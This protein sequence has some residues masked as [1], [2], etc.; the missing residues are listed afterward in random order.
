MRQQTSLDKLDL[1][2]EGK[3]AN[4][5]QVYNLAVFAL[6]AFLVWYLFVPGAESYYEGEQASNDKIIADLNRENNYLMSVSCPNTLEGDRQCKVNNKKRELNIAKSNL[7]DIKDYNNHFTDKLY[8]LSTLTYNA[9]NWAKFLDSLTTIANDNNVKIKAITSSPKVIL[10]KDVAPVLDI[11]VQF[12]GQFNK[13]LSFLNSI[14]ES[15]LVVDINKMDLNST[16]T[17]IF[18]DINIAIWGIKFQ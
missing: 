13:V 8:E 7:Q 10:V 14:E 4:E 11:G 17:G 15:K 9:E 3:S 6:I 1:Y 5:V 12:A 2:L 16:S 18:G